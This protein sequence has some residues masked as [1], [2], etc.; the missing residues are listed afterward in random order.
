MARKK[1]KGSGRKK[2]LV[3]RVRGMITDKPSKSPTGT[4]GAQRSK[5]ID[6]A[7][8]AM[9][10]GISDADSRKKRKRKK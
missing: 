2:G 1:P 4:G 5:S 8:A 7:V 9:E 3:D 6:D 10:S